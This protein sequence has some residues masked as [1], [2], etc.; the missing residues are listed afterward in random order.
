MQ[1][2][3]QTEQLNYHF[4]EINGFNHKVINQLDE[5]NISLIFTYQKNSS[6][7]PYPQR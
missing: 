7:T 4:V 5:K 6:A 3:Q 1:Q 2:L